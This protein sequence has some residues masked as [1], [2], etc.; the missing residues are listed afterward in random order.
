MTISSATSSLTY[1]GNDVTTTFPFTFPIFDRTH[2]VV[3]LIAYAPGNAEVFT[4]TA[5]IEA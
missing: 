4:L 5:E 2:L 3:T 1:A